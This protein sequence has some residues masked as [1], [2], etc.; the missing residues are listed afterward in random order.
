M[1]W[2]NR[3]KWTDDDAAL[4]ERL[5]EEV[6][7]KPLEYVRH[8]SNARLDEALRRV[9]IENGIG[10][11]GLWWVLVECL[12]SKRGHVYD[13][14]DDTG[15]MQLAM[16]MSTCGYMVEPDLCRAFVGTLAEV[17]LVNAE[18]LAEKGHVANDRVLKEC[19]KYAD[20][21]AVKK[22]SGIVSGRAR[23]QG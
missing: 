1:A 4:A 3:S 14:S 7:E 17:G 10:Y 8:D 6:S 11:L 23:R 22:V 21:C 16:D 18:L 15:W 13:V 2:S 12:C 9:V 20:A 19:W 5:R